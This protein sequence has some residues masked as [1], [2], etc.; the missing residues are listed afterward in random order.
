[1]LSGPRAT[2]WSVLFIAGRGGGGEEGGGDFCQ[3]DGYLDLLGLAGRAA[4]PGVTGDREP[5]A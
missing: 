2:A 3:Q 4:N 1:M 5:R